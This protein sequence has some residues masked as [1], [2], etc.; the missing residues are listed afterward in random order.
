VTATV[1]NESDRAVSDVEIDFYLTSPDAFAL[2]TLSPFEAVH[3]GKLAPGE[4]HTVSRRLPELPGR[5][6][7]SAV[8][9]GMA[10]KARVADTSYVLISPVTVT[11]LMPLT[12]PFQ[13]GRREVANPFAYVELY[14]PTA[15]SIS[16]DG[17]RL[18]GW[19]TIGRYPNEAHTLSLDGVLLPPASTL[20]VWLRSDDTL[21]AADFNA[22]Y[23][24]KLLLGEDLIIT[25]KPLLVAD[26]CGRRLDLSRGEEL[27]SRV[28]YGYYGTHDTDVVEDRPI[29]YRHGPDMT[30]TGRYLPL[31]EGEIPLPGR[32]TA[33]Q[34][35]KTMKG[36]CRASEEAEAQKAAD[37][38]RVITRLT[39]ASL[40]PFRAASFVANAVSAVKGFFD[41]KE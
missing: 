4:V 8:V 6:R 15:T 29:C 10:G 9:S 1:K 12:S 39:K 5:H 30:A 17:Y 13:K 34:V 28:T 2:R 25:E 24:T 18:A 27:L 26:G 3:V 41:I 33:K 11:K 21:T 31:P 19:H 37:R 36:L 23:G 32:V 20:T 38:E 35:P 22:R 40:V 7:V 16:L 14:N